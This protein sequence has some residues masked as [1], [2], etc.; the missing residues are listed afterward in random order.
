V[1]APRTDDLHLGDITLP[2]PCHALRVRE[3]IA[4]KL[5]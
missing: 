4:F 5:R 3:L 1:A 2:A